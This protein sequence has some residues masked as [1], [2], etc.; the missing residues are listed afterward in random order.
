M[1]GPATAAEQPSL[2]EKGRSDALP[3]HTTAPL[4]TTKDTSS[5]LSRKAASVLFCSLL[6]LANVW[7][8]AISSSGLAQLAPWLAP[9]SSSASGHNSVAWQPCNE[10]GITVP[11]FVCGSIRVPKDH[12]NSSVGSAYI[13]LAKY[14]ATVPRSEKIGSLYLNPGG[15]GG[16]GVEFAY[17][18]ANTLSKLT[19]GR[20]D[21]IGFDPRGIGRT[22][23]LVNCFGNSQQ[24]ELFKAG[25]VLENGFALPPDPWSKEGK[26][27][28]LRQIEELTA[29]QETEY[30]KCAQTM[31]E[32]ELR[33]MNT[34]TVVR[35]IDSMSKAFDGV[36]G[37]INFFG[38]VSCP[39]SFNLGRY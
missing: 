1:A 14:P 23:P 6:C 8:L 5:R 28:L 18:F 26:A 30:R 38:G 32:E 15:P 33:Y 2:H 37:R 24:H 3:Q 13:A 39:L 25:T 27:H 19:L 31:G 4:A 7:L 16:S 17:G 34:A 29:L 9:W 21:I 36:D 20:Y 35:D 11:D 12:F 10:H 22:R